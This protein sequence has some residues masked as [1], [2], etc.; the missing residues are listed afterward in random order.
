MFEKF[1]KTVADYFSR[2]Y[3]DNQQ[4]IEFDINFDNDKN[5]SDSKNNRTDKNYKNDKIDKSSKND[6]ITVLVRYE[7]PKVCLT[8]K[9]LSL[10]YI[11]VQAEFNEKE[12]SRSE[13]IETQTDFN[14]CPF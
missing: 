8:A 14:D 2:V 13:K 10:T 7:T 11:D 12:K 9:K 5:N 4:K 3:Q 6:N 1:K